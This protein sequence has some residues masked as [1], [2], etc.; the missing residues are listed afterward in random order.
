MASAVDKASELLK[1]W[2]YLQTQQMKEQLTDAVYREEM[3]RLKEAFRTTLSDIDKKNEVLV[4]VLKRANT[5]T[6]KEELR[7][8]LGE[9]TD[10][11]ADKLTEA[12]LE[13]IL[14]GKKK[15]EI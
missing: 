10:T 12:E 5:A 13:D 1:N 7:K 15:L 14:S 9:L 6:D 3:S 2:S 11:P 8:A 4:E